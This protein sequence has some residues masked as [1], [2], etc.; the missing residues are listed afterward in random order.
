MFFR[1]DARSSERR[2]TL[3]RRPTLTKVVGFTVAK[4]A[5]FSALFPLF[6][7]AS[8]LL[9]GFLSDRLG[10][11]GRAMLS[12]SRAPFHH[13]RAVRCLAGLRPGTTPVLPVVLVSLAG[14]VVIGPYSYLAGAMALDFGGK[15]AGATSS[16][17][18]DGVGYLGGVLSGD[19]VARLS[20]AA[21]WQGA[22]S[23]LGAVAA[24]SSLAAAILFALQ[25]RRR[26]PAI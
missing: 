1:W 5:Q 17:I 20:L 16:G 9:F 4:S 19:A 26:F 24:L 8:V 22:F 2:S 14:F 10:R 11:T 15:Q 3:G 23:I 21:G 25:R 18:I 7:G 13:G 6:G 12:F